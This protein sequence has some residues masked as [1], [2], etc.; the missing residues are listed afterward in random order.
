MAYDCRDVA[1]IQRQRLFKKVRVPIPS[2]MDE[3]KFS[4]AKV[5]TKSNHE[6]LGLWQRSYRLHD[7][8]TF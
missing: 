3:K 4:K 7:V 1:I 2:I 5:K 6:F 8:I